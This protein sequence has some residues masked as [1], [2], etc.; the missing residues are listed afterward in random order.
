M[1][2]DKY[3]K[4]IRS[5][6]IQLEDTDYNTGYVSGLVAMVSEHIAGLVSMAEKFRCTTLGEASSSEATRLAVKLVSTLSKHKDFEGLK[7]YE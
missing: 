2:M 6:E 1:G 3:E 7:Q 5:I 4:A